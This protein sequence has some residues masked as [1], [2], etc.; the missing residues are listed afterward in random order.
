MA[1][2]RKSLKSRLNQAVS[3]FERVKLANLP[4]P[5]AE[6]ENVPA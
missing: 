5:L 1:D 4:T 2:E 6:L 3:N